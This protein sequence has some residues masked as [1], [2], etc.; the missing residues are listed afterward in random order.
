MVPE[1]ARPGHARTARLIARSLGALFAVAF[2]ISL[3]QDPGL[4]GPDG[5][6]PATLF[7]E[8]VE[9]AAGDA[10]RWR[11]PTLFWW[12]P[13]TAAALRGV[14]AAGLALSLCAA[15]GLTHPLVHGGIWLLY[16]SLVGVGQRFTGFAWES[17]LLEAGF[18]AI[19]LQ[20]LRRPGRHE[21]PV[22][23]L[24]LWRWL[25]V[26]LMLGA[27]LIKLRGDP[28]WRELTCL[29]WHY[30]TQPNPHPLSWLLHQAPD[31]FHAVGVGVNHVVE[32]GLP[33]LLLGPRRVRLA[34]GAGL[35]LFQV[36]LIGSGNLAFLNWLTLI[37]CLSALDDGA[38][39]RW[40]L[41]S[42]P[43]LRGPVRPPSRPWRIAA[44][45]LALFVAWR[46]VGP[47]KNLLRADQV[48][49]TAYD[50]LRLVNSYGAFGSVGAVR[51]EISIEGTQ[52]DPADPA[53]RW[54][55]Y[56]LPCK[57]G[58]V[59]RRPCLITPYHLRLD[60]QMWFVPLAGVDRQPWLLPLLW[61]L[62]EAEPVV[63]DL[64]EA[65][66]FGGQRP[67]AVRVRR[68]RYRFAPPGAD[69]WWEREAQG[70]LIRPVTRDDP[71]LARVLDGL[72]F[73]SLVSG[74][75]GAAPGSR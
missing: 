3:L 61:R 21:P 5:I 8:Q 62:L 74:R 56:V 67:R 68:W 2:T 27:G 59:E 48:M 37:V 36:L 50:P 26:R 35:L 44:A 15:A 25:T 63:L 40:G 20:P 1:P 12:L 45:L 53:A 18:L 52:D 6:L 71:E 32:L 58:P 57:P 29:Q 19:A 41:P 34:A 14:A 13:P 17:L 55:E 24:W 10:S 30:E 28:C 70:V 4:V 69:G 72:G 65:D 43:A 39:P 33:L 51:E 16:L 31:G 60:W 73:G 66:P 46:S 7:L 64:F 42:L 11:L 22:V 49:N 38:L 9:A 54:V 23:V 47:V 75:P